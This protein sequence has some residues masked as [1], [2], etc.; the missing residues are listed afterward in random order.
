MLGRTVRSALKTR[1]GRRVGKAVAK[2][3]IKAGRTRGGKGA[4]K[5][6]ARGMGKLV[7]TGAKLKAGQKA[8]KAS[9]KGAKKAGKGFGKVA[10]KKGKREFRVAEKNLKSKRSGGGLLKYVLIAAVGLGI[11]VLLKRSGS[12]DS[13]SITD[14]NGSQATGAD[15]AHSDP[16][17]GPLIGEEHRENVAGV[18][19]DQPEIEQRIKTRIGEDERT[20][21]MPRVN[22]EVNEGVAELRGSASSEEVKEAAGEI[23]AD[24]EGVSEVRNLIEVSS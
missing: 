3:A 2:E 18:T 5:S 4:A 22:V 8:G 1:T 17:S 23:A 12:Q 21:D 24:T 19:E 6:G 13:S 11:F 7:K 9:A 14:T 16:S 15:R 20:R 10:S